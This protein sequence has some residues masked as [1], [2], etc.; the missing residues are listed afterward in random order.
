MVNLIKNGGFES[1]TE[2]WGTG[3]VEER[4]RDGNHPED[5]KRLPYV[6]GDK[7]KSPTNSEGRIDTTRS[8]SFGT[9][10]FRLEHWHPKMNHRWGSL[11]QRVFGLEP[12]NWYVVTFWVRAENANNDSFFVTTDI[13]WKIRTYIP[14]G[15]YEWQKVSHKF[16]SGKEP[17]VD[18]RFVIESPS[19]VWLDDV[20]VKPLPP[21]APIG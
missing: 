1:D 10:S 4:I 8:H 5:L 12:D 20:S 9:A 17:Y 16:Y 7:P 13:P 3:S 18:V 15:T 14:A 19:V 21:P 6:V 11:C 2:F